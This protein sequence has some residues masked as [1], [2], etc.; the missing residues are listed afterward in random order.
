MTLIVYKK[1]ALQDFWHPMWEYLSIIKT[2][3][4]EVDSLSTTKATAG[5]QALLVSLALPRRWFLCW[6]GCGMFVYISIMSSQTT[7]IRVARMLHYLRRICIFSNSRNWM[8]RCKQL[9]LNLMKKNL[10]LFWKNPSDNHVVVATQCYWACGVQLRYL[11]GPYSYIWCGQHV[12]SVQD[13][14]G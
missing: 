9:N 14:W 10:L 13:V 12:Y 11:E 1:S 2:A 5:N 6:S 3:V 4:Q 7:C 8:S